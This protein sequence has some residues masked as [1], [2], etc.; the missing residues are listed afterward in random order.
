[1]TFCELLFENS[2]TCHIHSFIFFLLSVRQSIGGPGTLKLKVRKRVG[3]ASDSKS[4]SGGSSRG[5]TAANDW[6]KEVCLYA[7][8]QQQN[9]N[10][11]STLNDWVKAYETDQNY[12]PVDIRIQRE[13]KR[14][15]VL[16]PAA[17]VLPYDKTTV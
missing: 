13:R 1:M 11:E 3:S 6:Y 2:P 16:Q 15:K 14:L 9:A 12:E 17:Q 5:S 4:R 7:L 8:K 10:P